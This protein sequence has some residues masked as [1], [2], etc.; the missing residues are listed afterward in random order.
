MAA[1][2]TTRT[3]SYKGHTA[4]HAVINQPLIVP[5]IVTGVA[6]LIFFTIIKTATGYHGLLYL[7]AAQHRVLYSVRLPTDS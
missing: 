3:A 2:W 7:I 6:L 5:D 4:I 1:L